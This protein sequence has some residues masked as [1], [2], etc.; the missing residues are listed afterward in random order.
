MIAPFDLLVPRH[1]PN[2][3]LRLRRFLLAAL[4]Y[5]VAI[6]LM[7]LYVVLGFMTLAGW[8]ITT[9][10]IV[11]VNLAIFAVLRSGRN[12]TLR[13]PSLTAVQ[14]FC[15][16]LLMALTMYQVDSARGALL[17][18][19]LVLLMFGVLRLRT[20]QFMALGLF[21]L[22]CYA[23]AIAAVWQTRP[24]AVDMDVELLQLAAM[25]TLV[26]CG[27]FFAGYVGGLRRKLRDRH[28]ALQ[29]VREQ[30]HDL[31]V[32]DPLTAV[33]N[34]SRIIESLEYEVAR[35]ARLEQPLSVV[36][37]DLDRF[38]RINRRY[39]H[40]VGDEVLKRIAERLQGALRSIDGLGRYGGEEFLVVLPDTGLA[41]ASRFAER[42]RE[43]VEGCRFPSLPPSVHLS[44]SIGVAEYRP[45][46]DVWSL[47]E[48][49]R[50]AADE[51]LHAGGGRIDA[52]P[53]DP[54][55]Q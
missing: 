45:G 28:I 27:G 37:L 38:K 18:L 16:C 20:W 5:L 8:Q 35:A 50:G 23:A 43:R 46:D 14:M 3:S 55:G 10:A 17:L 33:S 19:Y 22:V 26:P 15:T 47:V 48:R 51:A 25:A 41:E 11:A 9:A 1:D 13:D 4:V 6:G 36:M 31:R 42:L 2:Q 24:W 32:L 52:A 44:V 40:P 49:A 12:E 21:A 34:R 39:G 29:R 53:P 7:G 54:E 30:A